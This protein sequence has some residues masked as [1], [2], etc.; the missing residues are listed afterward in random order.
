MMK[1]VATRLCSYLPTSTDLF[2]V[3]FS[4]LRLYSSTHCSSRDADVCYV[5]PKS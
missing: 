1:L 5:H 2:K 4:S 3:S